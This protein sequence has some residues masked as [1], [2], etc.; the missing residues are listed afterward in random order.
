MSFS[1]LS[2]H[3]ISFVPSET[4]F[5]KKELKD[6]D[7]EQGLILT[8]FEDCNNLSEKNIKEKRGIITDMNGNLVC[9]TFPFID[10]YT[11]FELENKNNILMT[12]NLRFFESHEG[13]LVRLYYYNNHWNLSTHKK[14]NAFDSHWG[15]KESFGQ[16]FINALIHEVKT[17]KILEYEKEEDIFDRYC[18]MLDPNY[19]YCYL[20][21]NTLENR[22]VCDSP[23]NPTLFCLGIF[24]KQGTLQVY[25]EKQDEKVNSYIE[26][27]LE[28]KFKSVREVFE[29]VN[30][31]YYR[32]LQGLLVYKP[33][34]TLFKIL[35]MK[36]HE[37]Y[38]IR[39]NQP[40]LKFRYLQIR[41]NEELV[42]KLIS[43]YPYKES[44]F[45]FYEN[46]LR[47]L[48][49]K[50]FNAYIKRFIHKEY[51]ILEKPQYALMM[52]IHSKYIENK[53]KITQ[54]LVYNT[55]NDLDPSKLMS[56]L[57]SL[58]KNN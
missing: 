1:K 37:L 46:N 31:I 55:I 50:I 9:K 11:P 44:R 35:N 15:S 54:E 34:G 7:L 58:S 2:K 51:I 33:D 6:V 57:R 41:K 21:K 56:L 38:S 25:D 8:H 24:D 30:N 43:L 10:E 53:I 29:Y 28:I 26:S 45:E 36:Y 12:K 48:S 39:G 52:N 32:K 13:T 49:I 16:M 42:K 47:L 18:M 22:I 14:I 40:S 4:S 27:P 19:V 3:A 20:V 17:N 5:D 23:T